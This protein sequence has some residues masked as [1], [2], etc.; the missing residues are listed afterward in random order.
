MSESESESDWSE[1]SAVVESDADR[2]RRNNESLTEIWIK[3]WES[4]AVEVLDALKNSTVVKYVR[5]RFYSAQLDEEALVKLSEVMKCNKSVTFLNINLDRW[6][7][8][9]RFFATLGTS[10]GWSSIQELVLHSYDEPEYLSLRE[11][12]HISNFILQCENLRTLWLDMAGDE[13]APIVEILSRTK[14]KSLNLDFGETFSLQ[15]GGRQLATALERCNSITELCLDFRHEVELDFF[16]ILLVESIPKMLGLKKLT[17]C[18]SLR[19]RQ[20]F[21]HKF[22]DMVGQCIGLHQGDIEELRLITCSSASENSSIVGL[23]PALRRL[24]VIRFHGTGLSS[25]HIGELLGIVRD[26]DALEEFG[27]MNLFRPTESLTE[28]S[29]DDFKAICQLLSKFP[30]LKRVAKDIFSNVDLREEGR[31]TAFLEMV[32]TSKTIEQVP[33][34][35]CGNAEKVAAI[36]YHCRN[37][38]IHNRIHE[39]GLL[40]ANVPDSAWPLILKEFSDVPDVLYYLLH[41]KNGAMIGPTR[42][43]C[44]RKQDFVDLK[45]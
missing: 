17:L 25:Q 39:E 18:I 15:N 8:R 43:G 30:S 31:L 19:V 22:F 21:D 5:V 38:R 3:D 32:K 27:C 34:F 37:N 13:V 36:K 23:T 11:A 7:L 1:T 12:E 29:T 14:V 41:Q 2:I 45:K 28:I 42:H 26:C 24:K 44:K 33:P 6:L 9:E 40:A 4:D 35:R 10:G 16:Q 20:Q